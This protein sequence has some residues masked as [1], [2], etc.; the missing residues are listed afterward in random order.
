M[1]EGST[2]TAD[3]ATNYYSLESNKYTKKNTHT[4]SL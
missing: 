2:N 4:N 1:L 3:F